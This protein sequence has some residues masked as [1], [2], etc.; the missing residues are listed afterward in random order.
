MISLETLLAGI[1]AFCF[2][3]ASARSI[4]CIGFKLQS[5]LSTVLRFNGFEFFNVFV[6]SF[7]WGNFRMIM[8]R[9]FLGIFDVVVLSV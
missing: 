2:V 3:S 9:D 5:V 4:G 6:I 1:R 7:E 8:V